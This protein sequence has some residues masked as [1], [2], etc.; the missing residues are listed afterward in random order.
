MN[1]TDIK[2]RIE[3]LESRLMHQ[4]AT[5]DELTRTL[6]NQEQLLN[7]QIEIIKRLEEQVRGMSTAHPGTTTNEP[8]PPHY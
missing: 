5:L 1:D 3:S 8:P 4:D 6:L 7:K 2:T